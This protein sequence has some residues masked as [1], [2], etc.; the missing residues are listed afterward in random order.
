M[1]KKIS[2]ELLAKAM[3]DID[4]R[5]IADAHSGNAKG[6]AVVK[7]GGRKRSPFSWRWV[8]AAAAVFVLVIAGSFIIIKT[9][10]GKSKSLQTGA[11]GFDNSSSELIISNSGKKEDGHGAAPEQSVKRP[12]DPDPSVD[13]LFPGEDHSGAPG[14]ENGAPA[15][16]DLYYWYDGDVCR[17]ALMLSE[18]SV[19][20]SSDPLDDRTARNYTEYAMQ[21]S[22]TAGELR[23]YLSDEANA[24]YLREAI[25]EV[26]PL[27]DLVGERFERAYSVPKYISN[28][29]AQENE[30][31]S[32]SDAPDGVRTD[33]TLAEILRLLNID[34]YAGN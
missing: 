6:E 21:N 34:N 16:V 11:V 14:E 29:N 24:A 9:A 30:T 13:E 8:T 28:D 18:D 5:F 15:P 3:N 32:P 17:F 26:R 33:D 7:T 20:D 12:E 19:K 10:G 27:R 25:E 31:G 1:N 4:D 22:F 2:K 23:S